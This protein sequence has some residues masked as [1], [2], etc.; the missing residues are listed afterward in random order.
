MYNRFFRQYPEKCIIL[1]EELGEG[2]KELGT[3]TVAIARLLKQYDLCLRLIER[4]NQRFLDFYCSIEIEEYEQLWSQ[5]ETTF[6]ES[7]D[8]DN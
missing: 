7:E 3:P 1:P 5:A 6:Y 4:K 2:L 8:S